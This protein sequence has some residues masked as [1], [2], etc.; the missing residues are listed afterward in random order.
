MNLANLPSDVN[1]LITSYLS[2]NDALTFTRVSRI[3]RDSILANLIREHRAFMKGDGIDG[4]TRLMRAASERSVDWD[5]I[6]FIVNTL[7]RQAVVVQDEFGVTAIHNAVRAGSLEV[8]RLLCEKG[9]KEAVLLRNSL[10]DSALHAAVSMEDMD[11]V[12][13]LCEVGGKELVML[14]NNMGLTAMY[15]AAEMGNIEIVYH[16]CVV[17]GKDAVSLQNK[18]GDTPLTI[19]ND[20]FHA[21]IVVLLTSVQET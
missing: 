17:G 6:R 13:L 10:G 16:L 8:I 3:I 4:S 5:K 12:K 20:R 21:D 7:G 15:N 9:G 1:S 19:A 18:D 11:V 14:R 2:R